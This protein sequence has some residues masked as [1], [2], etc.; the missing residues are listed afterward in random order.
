MTCEQQIIESAALQPTRATLDQ[1]SD[2]YCITN[3]GCFS[4]PWV[5]LEFN[6]I[7]LNQANQSLL[8]VCAT[9]TQPAEAASGLKGKRKKKRETLT[10]LRQTRMRPLTQSTL[11]GPPPQIAVLLLFVDEGVAPSSF[12][13]TSF[14]WKLQ[15]RSSAEMFLRASVT[16]CHLAC[17]AIQSHP[18]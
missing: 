8:D 11:P 18:L 10:K 12:A 15:G 7:C 1:Q 3:Q 17:N 2:F 9:R 13:D 16:R 6:T 4:P 5:A 14:H